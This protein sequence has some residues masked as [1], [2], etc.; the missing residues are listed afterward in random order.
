MSVEGPWEIGIFL[1][2]KNNNKTKTKTKQIQHCNTIFLP[3][4]FNS[5]LRLE[6]HHLLRLVSNSLTASLPPWERE[7]RKKKK[8][9]EK[10]TKTNNKKKSAAEKADTS[11]KFLSGKVS[12]LQ[13]EKWART[14]ES[15]H[16]WSERVAEAMTRQ[17]G[18]AF[19]APSNVSASTHAAHAPTQQPASQSY[20]CISISSR[21]KSDQPTALIQPIE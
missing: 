20:S 12:P 5:F 16:D 19:D 7:K 11:Q 14:R 1:K 4:F 15:Q 3:S 9:K 21:R 8:R 6:Q 2:T 13:P 18:L 10:I 17:F